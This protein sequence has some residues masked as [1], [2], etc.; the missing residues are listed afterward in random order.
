MDMKT[1]LL[2][3]VWENSMNIKLMSMVNLHFLFK[4]LVSSEIRHTSLRQQ[5][6]QHERRLNNHKLWRASNLRSLNGEEVNY[7][8]RLS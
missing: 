1:V 6:Q 4:I 3:C 5:Q 8:A 2:G 7:L